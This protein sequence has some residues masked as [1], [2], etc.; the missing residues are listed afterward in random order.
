MGERWGFVGG[1]L[2]W[3]PVV[4]NGASSPAIVL[5]F[6]LLA[7]HAELGLTVSIILQLVILW[8]VVALALA[9]LAANRRGDERGVHHLLPPR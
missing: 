1:C 9:R 3:I 2:S 5:Q 7:F 6:L 4:L 8:G